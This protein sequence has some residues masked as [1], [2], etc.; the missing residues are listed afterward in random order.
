MRCPRERHDAEPKPLF[1]PEAPSWF[2]RV[3]TSLSISPCF[4]L[5]LC[6]RDRWAIPGSFRWMDGRRDDARRKKNPTIPGSW[7]LHGARSGVSEAL[8]VAGSVFRLGRM[9]APRSVGRRLRRADPVRSTAKL[10]LP[11]ILRSARQVSRAADEIFSVTLPSRGR[12]VHLPRYRVP[13]RAGPKR[14]DR[15]RGRSHRPPPPHRRPLG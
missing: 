4:R 14:E 9:V 13:E 11:I 5:R 3:K 12:S 10:N 7:L 1:Q 2:R 8:S 15:D 6:M